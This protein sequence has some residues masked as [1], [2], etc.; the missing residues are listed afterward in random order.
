MH[1]KK[2]F[3]VPNDLNSEK[4]T[5]PEKHDFNGEPKITG[6]VT[7]AM[8]KPM[9]HKNAAQLAINAL[10]DLSKKHCP[11]CEWEQ[12]TRFTINRKAHMRTN[13]EKQLS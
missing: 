6:P 8:K 10:C 9:D 4:D 12:E 2:F 11:M 1:L 7:R 5:Q 3:S 13:A